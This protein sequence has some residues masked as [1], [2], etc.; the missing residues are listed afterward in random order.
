M[1]ALPDTE[2]LAPCP[3]C[4]GAPY[5]SREYDNDTGGA[6]HAY[7]CRS[8][9]AKSGD[10]YANETCGQFFAEL[11]DAWNAR[12]DAAQRIADAAR[13]AELEAALREA[14]KCLEGEPEYHPQGMGCGLEDRGITDRYD[15]MEHGWEQAMERVYGEH[16]NGAREVIDAALEPRP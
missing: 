9:R 15:A 14:R 7:V 5:L 4:G 8:C 13:I 10:K 16:I 3:F 11:R 6:F 12:T 2:A 1:S